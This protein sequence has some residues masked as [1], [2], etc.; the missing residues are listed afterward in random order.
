MFR[1]VNRFKG[2]LFVVLLKL[3]SSSP[4]RVGADVI[5][6]TNHIARSPLAGPGSGWIHKRTI[7]INNSGTGATALTEYQVKV[8]L[9]SGN[10]DF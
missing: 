1:K 10:F 8:S 9:T 5:A 2:V 7:T 3:L 4:V 6:D